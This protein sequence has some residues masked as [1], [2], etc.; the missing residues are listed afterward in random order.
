MSAGACEAQAA[1]RRKT[2]TVQTFFTKSVSSG[3]CSA[4]EC[5][6]P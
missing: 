5:V 4:E 6:L 1:R 2:V 3:C